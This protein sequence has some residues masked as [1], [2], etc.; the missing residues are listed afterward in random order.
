MRSRT[1]G[2]K[3]LVDVSSY[4]GVGRC[5]C[6]HYTTRIEPLIRR[7]RKPEEA[8]EAGVLKIQP[9]HAGPW[10]AFLCWHLFRARQAL[11]D[12]FIKKLLETEAAQR[13]KAYR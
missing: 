10:E 5:S 13:E 3:Y 11:V 8:I 1:S 2:K 6:A 4:D 9:F 12:A 7:G